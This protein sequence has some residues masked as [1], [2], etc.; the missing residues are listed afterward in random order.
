[1]E[2]RKS[3]STPSATSAAAGYGLRKGRRER[4]LRGAKATRRP[5]AAG[6]RREND[7]E[8]EEDGYGL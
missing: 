6:G 5:A 1:M 3:L 4:G 2:A 7:D 8:D